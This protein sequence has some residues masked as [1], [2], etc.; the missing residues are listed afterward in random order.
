MAKTLDWK[1]HLR[2]Y[3][4]KGQKKDELHEPKSVNSKST[5]AILVDYEGKLEGWYK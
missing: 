4:G 1:F 5:G 2:H 3:L